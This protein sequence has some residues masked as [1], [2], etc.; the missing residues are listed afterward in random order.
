MMAILESSKIQWS[1]IS[2]DIELN[3]DSNILTS[4]IVQGQGS[5]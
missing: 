1:F 3:Q 5:S 4:S 2:I